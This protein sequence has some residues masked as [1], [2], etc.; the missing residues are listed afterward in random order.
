MFHPI[1]LSFAAKKPV[2]VN[3][4]EPVY[5]PDIGSKGFKTV[6]LENNELTDEAVQ[7]MAEIIYNPELA[8]EIATYNFE[9]G[10]KYFSYDTLEEKLQ[11]LIGLA[12]SLPL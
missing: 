12:L 11:E 4:Y 7:D 1:G 9:L 8:E 5:M 10:K 2:F 6:M 3:N